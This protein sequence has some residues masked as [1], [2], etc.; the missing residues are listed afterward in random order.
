MQYDSFQQQQQQ[1]LKNMNGNS[2]RDTN[3]NI[4]NTTDCCVP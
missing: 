4:H 3:T 1:T 2:I